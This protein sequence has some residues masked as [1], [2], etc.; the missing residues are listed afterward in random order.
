MK[1]IGP[2]LIAWVLGDVSAADFV[3]KRPREFYK[4][5]P[6]GAKIKRL[7]TGFKFTEGPQWV[8]AGNG[9]L[10]FSD[11][12]ADRLI[13]WTA[14]DGAVSFRRPSRNAN[15]NT[16]DRRGH[17]V[18]C[19]HGA[20]RVSITD[21]EGKVRTLVDSFGGKKLN[22][23]NDV[24][25]SMDGNIW[26]TDPDYGL[27]DR[28]KEQSGNFVFRHGSKSGQTAIVARGFDKP[29]G[30]CFSPAEK[31]L[32]VADSGKSRHIRVF[33]VQV[34]G[35]LD[36]GRVFCAIDKGAPDGI[37]CDKKGRVWSSAG[38]GVHIFSIDG[39]LVGKILVPEAPANLCFGGETMQTLFITAR[40]SLYS[41]RVRA[42]GI[43]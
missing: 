28:T 15:G 1:L 10:V 42:Q 17:L 41:I 43:R 29:N 22:S 31:L 35:T 40:T 33:K 24:V 19:E 39:G 9:H 16:L 26:F 3:L 5:V 20:R 18:T 8:P 27:K 14:S 12:P 23:P 4:A 21:V 2:I 7:A 11:I 34:D 25:V 36:A 37:R 6:L 38:D 13:K 32:Y 30:L